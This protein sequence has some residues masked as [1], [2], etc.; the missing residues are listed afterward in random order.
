MKYTT[1]I[2]TLTFLLGSIVAFAQGT[3]PQ[4]LSGTYE[5]MVKRPGG[6]TEEKVALELK[7][8]GGK[9]TARAIHGDKN[10]EATDAKF[11]N[12]TLT[13]SFDKDHKFTAKVD[14]DKLVGEFTD[15]PQKF[16]LELK[17][18]TPA[19]APAATPAPAAPAPAAPAAA[20]PAAFNLN[21]QWDAVADANG[22]PFPFLL[23]LKV[24]GENVT[25]NSSSQLGEAQVKSGSWK[26]GKL[27]IELEG[28]N[29]SISLSATVSEGKLSG[30]F[31]YA[32]QLQ[33]RWVAVKKN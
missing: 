20:A 7:S 18:V 29:G 1:L 9:I 21:G 13:L 22:Q 27:A 5:A 10:V 4:N 25:G 15:G 3:T 28:P 17:K 8:E 2:L 30:E 16:P 11:E 23:T 32:G 24:D 6:T 14:G 33:G 19:A 12:G 26:D 31:D